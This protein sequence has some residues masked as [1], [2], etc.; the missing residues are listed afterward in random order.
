M[1]ASTLSRLVRRWQP[2]TLASLSGA[3]K[4]KLRSPPVSRAGEVCAVSLN[5]RP[6]LLCR[7][8]TMGPSRKC[9]HGMWRELLI[10]ALT[11][12]IQLAARHASSL[13]A[14]RLRTRHRP[15]IGGSGLD[16]LGAASYR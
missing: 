5:I 7:E 10:M 6:A 13:V 4:K 3:G 8:V 14:K 12:A 1:S 11:A 15:L 9:S 2:R 16:L